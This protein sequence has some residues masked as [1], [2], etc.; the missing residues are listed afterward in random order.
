M[1]KFCAKCGKAVEETEAFCGNCGASLK[2]GVKSEVVDSSNDMN[3]DSKGAINKDY[4]VAGFVCS[5]I[6]FL[7]CTYVA[8]PGL[9]FSIMSFNDMKSG[10][11][12]SNRKWMAIVGIIFSAF[13]IVTLLYNLFNPNQDIV[14][15]IEELM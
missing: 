5:L 9:V 10:K 1:A 15:M 3:S 8:I 11:I 7:C 4:T 6:G 13:G 2:E 14:K 12:S